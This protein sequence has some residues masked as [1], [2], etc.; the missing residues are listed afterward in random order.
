MATR[1]TWRRLKV[2]SGPTLKRRLKSD[3]VALTRNVVCSR[4]TAKQLSSGICFGRPLRIRKKPT[5]GRRRE[6]AKEVRGGFQTTPRLRSQNRTRPRNSGKSATKAFRC[7]RTKKIKLR[8]YPE[9]RAADGFPTPAPHFPDQVAT[10]SAIC[11]R[12]PAARNRR[13]RASL[14]I[15]L[16]TAK[17]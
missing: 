16:R 4:A 2:L 17:R 8:N 15:S 6:Q 5:T 12:R 9:N 11:K 7:L 1:L 3:D 10:E 13:C 14:H